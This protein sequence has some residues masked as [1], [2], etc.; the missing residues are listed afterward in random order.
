MYCP[1]NIRIEIPYR[2]A[3]WKIKKIDLSIEMG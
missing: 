3:F 2:G 1:L